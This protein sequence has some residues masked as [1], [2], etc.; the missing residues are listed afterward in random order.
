MPDN[1]RPLLPHLQ[2]YTPQLTSIMSVFHRFSGVG[3]IAA[4][5]LVC[6]W[7][8]VLCQGE[9]VYLDFCNFLA[10]PLVKLMVYGVLACVYYHLLNGIRYLMWSLGRGYELSCVYNSGWLVTFVVFVLIILTVYLV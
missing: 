5:C 4:M 2:I 7:I 3:F 10:Y 1:Q 8:Y 9:A 6:I